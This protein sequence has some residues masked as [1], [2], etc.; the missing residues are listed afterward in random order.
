MARLGLFEW[1]LT[2]FLAMVLWTFF[3]AAD[4][5]T[6][7]QYIGT[8]FG[9]GGSGTA[10]LPNDNAAGVL[11][12]VACVSLLALHW[13]EARLFT[14]RAAMLSSAMEWSISP[15]V[16]AWRLAVD[17]LLPKPQNTPFIYFRF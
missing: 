4:L 14:P 12:A 11:V 13:V 3:R 7:I 15:L 5:P 16:S 17:L 8:M 2:L 1:A 10:L 9:A 6:A